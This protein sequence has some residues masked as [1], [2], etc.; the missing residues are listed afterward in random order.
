MLEGRQIG[1]LVRYCHSASEQRIERAEQTDVLQLE[2][3][4][5]RLNIRRS[6]LCCE[7]LASV[8]STDRFMTRCAPAE[9]QTNV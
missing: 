9:M 3:I 4:G 5:V 1:C 7:T 8:S 6:V 2:D